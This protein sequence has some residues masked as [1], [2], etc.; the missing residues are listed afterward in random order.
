MKRLAVLVLASVAGMGFGGC[1]RQDAATTI[2]EDVHGPV[3]NGVLPGQLPAGEPTILLDQTKFYKERELS[4]APAAVTAPTSA[5]AATT[6][7]PP[8]P[9]APGE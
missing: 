1:E 9:A 7:A 2:K 6:E 8:A 5:P 3:I 4:A